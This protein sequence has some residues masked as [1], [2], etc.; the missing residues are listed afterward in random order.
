VLSVT[1]G[2]FSQCYTGTG[3][4]GSVVPAANQEECCTDTDNGM[5][6]MDAGI[7]TQCTDAICSNG[8]LRLARDDRPTIGRL[9][10]CFDG[11]WTRVC[12]EALGHNEAKVACGQLGYSREF[13]KTYEDYDIDRHS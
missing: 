8:E 11:E 12:P 3:C 2:G 5:A 4:T 7:C 1:R 10:A 9:E 6:F 13:F